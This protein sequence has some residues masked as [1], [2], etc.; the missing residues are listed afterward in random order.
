M[1]GKQ[2]VLMVI[3]WL[4][5]VYGVEVKPERMALYAETLLARYTPPEVL[6]AGRGLVYSSRFFPSIADF[7]EAIEGKV[8]TL[9]QGILD[10][11]ADQW[12]LLMGAN[13]QSPSSRF[14]NRVCK[15]VTGTIFPG[16]DLTIRDAGFQRKAFLEMYARKMKATMSEDRQRLLDEAASGTTRLL[17]EG[18]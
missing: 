1:K 4:A 10:E 5:E 13:P 3:V 16:T 12:A 2:E 8:P 15:Q 7:V 14:A 11:A 9:D 6:K 17:E 18:S